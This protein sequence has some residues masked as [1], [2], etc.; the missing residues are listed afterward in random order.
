MDVPE[1]SGGLG[2]GTLSG[3]RAK[4][5]DYWDQVMDLAPTF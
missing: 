3:L 4:Q 2:F 1:S 5:C